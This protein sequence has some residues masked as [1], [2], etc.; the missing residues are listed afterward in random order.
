LLG[1]LVG[2]SAS[3]HIYFLHEKGSSIPVSEFYHDKEYFL[4][5]FGEKDFF[6]LCLFGLGFTFLVCFHPTLFMHPVNFLKADP[7]VTPEHIV[8]EWYFLPFYTILRVIPNKTLGIL[9]MGC[10]IFV[11][12]FLPF[13]NYLGFPKKVFTKDIYN[14]FF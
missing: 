8:P 3:L 11:L 2:A 7:L 13:Y 5:L 12:A 14:F 10:S 1:F 6:S 4:P 9:A